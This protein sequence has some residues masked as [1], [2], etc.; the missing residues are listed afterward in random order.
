MW[1]RCLKMDN[2]KKLAVFDLDGTLFDTTDVNYC[3]YR[4]AA[5]ECGYDIA[6]EEFV[7]VFVGKN[8]KEFLPIFGVEKPEIQ[9][10]IHE[11]KKEKYAGFLG[12][13]R[14]NEHLFSMMECMKQEYILAVATTA[15]RQN[16]CD[17]LNCFGVLELFDFL[18]TQ[19]NV[20][21]LKPDPECYFMAM[22]K[23]AVEAKKTI[24]F[25]DSAVGLNAAMSTG[26]FV[27]KV[28]KF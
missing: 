10:K 3:S 21:K 2:R 28:E 20:V 26:A 9:E 12:K 13:A 8:Y 18:I 15:S 7:K 1:R 19:E 17:I 27:L 14:K 25:E 6:Y 11:I 24:I 23:A 22:K 16:T 4:E 5:S